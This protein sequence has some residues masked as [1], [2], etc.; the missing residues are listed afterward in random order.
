MHVSV[1]YIRVL[2]YM[3]YRRKRYPPAML[4]SKYFYRYYSTGYS[5]QTYCMLNNPAK[6]IIKALTCKSS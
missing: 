2:L 4:P 3:R 5:H 6:E 1:L